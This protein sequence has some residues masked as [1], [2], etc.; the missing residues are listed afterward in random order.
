MQTFKVRMSRLIFL[1][2]AALSP[3]A[4][5]AAEESIG[6]K[7]QRLATEANGIMALILT[8]AQVVGIVFLWG[9]ISKIR[10]DKEQPG[11]GLMGQGL[12]GCA[13]GVF[14]YFLPRL[15]GVGAATLLP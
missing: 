9:G 12:M 2:L 14:L 10:K 15:L 8:A 13:I 1:V 11:Q 6:Q 5:F 4:V 3:L 7:S